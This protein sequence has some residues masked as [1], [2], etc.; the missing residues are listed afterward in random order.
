MTEAS[1]KRVTDLVAPSLEAGERI[2]ATLS[3]AETGS[4]Y[5]K[6]LLLAVPG[7][8]IPRLESAPLQWL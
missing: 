7:L 2:E 3:F 4:S 1:T 6:G 8:F 5:W